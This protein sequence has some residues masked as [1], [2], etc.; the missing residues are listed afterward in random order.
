MKSFNL[1]DWALEH[2]SLVWYFMIVFIL[3]GAFSYVKLGREE[4]PNFTIKTMVITAQWP[5][6]SAEEVTRQVTDRIEKKL[7]ELESLDYTK[8]E[9]VAGQTTVFVELLPTT[10]AKD[11]A[12]TWLRIRN[13]IADIK[14][15]FPTGVVGPFFNDRFGDVFGN[16]YAF[17]SDGLTQRQLRDLVENARSEVLTVPNVGKVDVVGAQDEAIYLE[18][19]TRQI[20]ALGIDQQSVIQTLQAQN[21]V[22]QSGF[23]DAGPE[24]IALRVS[25]QFT[26]E[27]SL[28][29]IN[30]RINDRF[31][32]LTDVATIKRGY[33]DPPSALFRFNGQPAIG[34]AI[35]MK[36][37]ANLLEFGE[38][39]DAQMKRVVADLPIGVDVHRV[40]DQPAVVDE[41]VSGFT[42]ALFEAI[43]IV[44][45]IS[46]ISL[47]LR[48]G[49]VVAISIPLVL[50][51]TFV[52]MEYS[53]ISLQR[54]S[55][56]ALIIALG[57]LV[58][59]AMIAVEMMVARLEAGDDLRKAATHVYTST[60][61]P[62]LTGTL[63]TVAGFIPVG[64]NNS[65]A[66][67]FTFTLFVVI[68]V[69]LI[70]SWVVAVLFTPLLGVTI[71]PKT[72]KSHHE[73]KG[74][75]AS[76]FSRL[77]GLAMRW[78]WVTIILTVGVFG[79][80][81][82]GM[83]LVQQQ[84]FPSSD[85]TELIIDWNLPHN[86]SIAETNRQMARFEKE[87]LADN[88]DIDHWTTYVGQGAPR[89]ILSFD[90]QTPNVSFGQTIIVT[91]GLDVRD[92]VRTGLQ[93]YLTK[94]FPGTDA[95]V[96]LLDIGPPVG[97]PVQYRVSGPDIQKV[98]DLSQKFAGV[99]GSDPLLANMVLD[100]N[101]PSRVVKVDVLQDKARQLGVSSEDI[102]TALNGI[103]EGS[104]ATQVRDDIYLVNVIGRARE[105]ER[106]SIQT[107]QNLQ[108]STANG[109]VVPL[110]AVANFRYELEQPTI[111]RRDRQPTIT[112]KAAVVGPTQ[113]ATVVEQLKPKVEEFQKSLPV[114]YKVEVGGAVESSA[115]AQGPIAAVAP[116]ML[117][118]MATILMIQ[119]Q[120]FSRLFLVFAVAPTALIGVVAALLLS[121]APM[122]FVAILGVL[123]LIGILIRNSVILVVQ[124]EHLRSEG[125]APWKAVIEATEHRM[126]PIMLTAAAA[127]LALIPISREIF[128]GPMAYAMMG[129]IV[130]G[131]A[132]TLLFLPA[133]YV[134]W[135][136]IPRDEGV[137][138]EAAAAE[139]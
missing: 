80:S 108:L 135:F 119:L 122:G 73:K 107:L 114:G 83:G 138:A 19:S 40:S 13:M 127:T 62:M 128:W 109:K 97:K 36:Q 130:V 35:G 56:G 24:R 132:L 59:D 78:R 86:S 14:G 118:A 21:A 48:A 104:T 133:L 105:S 84:F 27:E 60:A 58:D 112:V 96:K 30:L 82:G 66:G 123:A 102:A 32:P 75:F 53:G 38:G 106:D 1:S 47:G 101:E 64:L 139:V 103:V 74:R 9:T 23:V 50:A 46:F 45:I 99:I 16:I 41:A 10:K 120:S 93:D 65:A 126:R 124:I 125:M 15:D 131:T 113:P 110:S 91:K 117:F 39:L 61:F 55:L 25:G 18:F 28:R 17:T 11:V 70:V 72:M 77:L 71:L 54:I 3:A 33:V 90:V 85:R 4:D 42:R 52:V 29:S 2:R 121:N 26:S 137:R 76:V 129:G 43:V 115:E 88:K 134:A 87:M 34:L 116:L 7:Q 100:W 5:G 49:M 68:A 6:A 31:F 67:E 57:L 98:R 89:F 111:W 20:A 8:S 79:L 22:T 81:I 136:R 69:S 92:K 51:I 37:G 95:F 63:V 44:L 94:T 12:P